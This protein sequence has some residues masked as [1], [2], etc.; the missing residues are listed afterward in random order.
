[1][2]LKL[3]LLTAASRFG[4]SLVAGGGALFSSFAMIGGA[5]NLRMVTGKALVK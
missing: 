2:A 4:A 3:I 5:N 1:L